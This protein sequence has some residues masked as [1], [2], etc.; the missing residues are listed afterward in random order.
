MP[1]AEVLA[2]DT[3]CVAFVEQL[4]RTEILNA[5]PSV[6]SLS[7]ALGVLEAA[8]TVKMET[9]QRF[10]DNLET[11]VAELDLRFEGF[12]AEIQRRL[13]AGG[14]AVAS[15]R[16]KVKLIA[17]SVWSK[18]SGGS[19]SKDVLHAQVRLQQDGHAAWRCRSSSNSSTVGLPGGGREV[20]GGGGLWNG[21]TTCRRGGMAAAP[22]D[23][24]KCSLGSSHPSPIVVVQHLYNFTTLLAAP[25][26]A[27]KAGE[28]GRRQLDCAGVVTTCYAVCAML[29][30]R[31]GH[32][33]L[34]CIRMQARVGY[35]AGTCCE[36]ISC[37]ACGAAA[38]WGGHGAR[39]CWPPATGV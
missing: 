4:L 3:R 31:F 27:S 2:G 22:P 19:F 12:V 1:V 10:P 7:I 13:H 9:L 29:A 25:G 35:A 17:D 39:L 32:A 8:G 24:R 6:V 20:R 30:A 34:A 37:F 38:L 23:S 33:D 21:P 5:S 36:V 28:Q 14:E 16:S 26:G 11:T 18:L 15:P